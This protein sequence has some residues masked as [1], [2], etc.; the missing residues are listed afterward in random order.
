MGAVI[1]NDVMMDV[2]LAMV[3]PP[4][5]TTLNPGGGSLGPGVA[6]ATPGSMV[7]IYAGAIIAVGANGSA[8]QEAVTVTSVTATT[9]TATF[10][11]SHPNT[12][13]ITGMTFSKGLPNSPLFSQ[14]EVLQY[15]SDAQND[16]CLKVRPIYA[17]GSVTLTPGKKVYAAPADSI[18]VE[19]A[20]IVNASANPPTAVELY[21]Q[22]Q[23]DLDLL[24]YAWGTSGN[25][26]PTGWYQDQINTQTIGFGPPP[27]VGSPVSLFYSQLPTGTLGILS[28]FLIPDP[29][30]V[31]VKWRTLAVCFS[32][33]GETRAPDKAK[34]AQ[35]LY[36][37]IV[38]ASQKFLAGVDA[39]MRSKEET[40]EPLAS[41]R[42]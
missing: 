22:T 20:S 42:M 38:L 23:T 29:M 25:N 4:V 3:E 7:A 33:D 35:S 2:G 14:S 37:I 31:A 15:L 30:T 21:D 11:H 9:F 8:N 16:F 5:N 32:K 39:R 28:T 12:E 26:L 41:Q 17:V 18:R 27:Q 40:V 36:D 24:Q 34:F 13:P 6:T 19:R 1:A 10:V